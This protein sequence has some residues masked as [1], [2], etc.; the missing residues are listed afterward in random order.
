MKKSLYTNEKL[1]KIGYPNSDS[2]EYLRLF[3]QLTVM[4]VGMESKSGRSD[5]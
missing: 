3:D 1:T 4:I 2:T 5:R